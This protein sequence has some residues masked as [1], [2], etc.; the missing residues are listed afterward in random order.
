MTD[1]RTGAAPTPTGPPSTVDYSEQIPD[2]VNLAEDRRLPCPAGS[3]GQ[4]SL[5]VG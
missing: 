3:S 1:T 5:V 4:V 2:N